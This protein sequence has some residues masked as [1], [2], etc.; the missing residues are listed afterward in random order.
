LHYNIKT[1]NPRGFCYIFLYINKKASEKTSERAASTNSVLTPA[2]LRIAASFFANGPFCCSFDGFI[3]LSVVCEEPLGACVTLASA[4][5]KL[6]GSDVV[7]TVV[8][9]TV[10][11]GTVVIGTVVIGTKI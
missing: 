6:S 10:V 4:S 2:S 8:I 5:S 7:G 9:G 3:P 1:P 11:I